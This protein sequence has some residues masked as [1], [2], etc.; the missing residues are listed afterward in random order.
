[1]PYQ[2]RESIV[3]G[4][5]QRSS[6]GKTGA[7]SAHRAARKIDDRAPFVFP[8]IPY[9]HAFC[10]VK[11]LLRC[12]LTLSPLNPFRNES[13]PLAVRKKGDSPVWISRETSSEHDSQEMPSA[14]GIH[15]WSTLGWTITDTTKYHSSS[16]ISFS[17]AP[18]SGSEAGTGTAVVRL[19]HG[20]RWGPTFVPPHFAFHTSEIP[21][22][23][24]LLAFA[25]TVRGDRV[26]GR[27]KVNAAV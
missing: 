17:C 8:F 7:D 14:L 10:I 22:S 1:M 6:S 23:M 15:R 12:F 21:T 25:D 19:T 26:A 9:G 24:L 11:F 18:N 27:L 5:G 2:K 16:L 20:G 3:D 4:R 13:C